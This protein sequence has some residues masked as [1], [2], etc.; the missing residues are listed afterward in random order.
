MP[1]KEYIYA[2]ARIRARELTLLPQTFLEQ[3]AGAPSEEDALRLLKEHGWE[4]KG[5]SAQEMLRAEEEKT[6]ALMKELLGDMSAFDVFLLEVDYHNLKAAIKETCT[7]GKHAGIYREGGTL[8]AKEMETALAAGEYTGLPEEMREPAGEAMRVLLQT[9]DGQRC[10]CIIDRAAMTAIRSAGRRSESALLREY[11]ELTAAMGDI[12][13]AVRSIM[14]GKDGS[15]LKDALAPCDAF[16]TERLTE[17]ALQ[18]REPLFAYLENTEYAG[19]GEAIGIS[20]AAFEKWCDD[21]LIEKIRPQL[22]NPF[23]LDPLAA[24]YLARRM[25]IKSVRMILAG[26]HNGLS[27]PEILERV[28]KTYV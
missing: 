28:R 20:Y 3:L 2:V 14:T 13:I 23:G 12:R 6:W 1:D 25:E 22:S 4:D 16:D 27:E 7:A 11:G 9:R 21:Q 15:F 26:L 5:K 10:D 8:S 17:A 18:G 24:Y 19:A